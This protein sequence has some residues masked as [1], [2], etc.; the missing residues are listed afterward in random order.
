MSIASIASSSACTG[1][2]D[3]AVTLPAGVNPRP[4]TA[5]AIRCAS[6]VSR[7]VTPPALR[8]WTDSSTRSA[9]RSARRCPSASAPP[10]A[11][12]AAATALPWA[13]DRTGTDTASAPSR[14]R[15]PM[16]ATAAE[17]AVR[18]NGASRSGSAIQS[19]C[20]KGF[21]PERTPAPLIGRLTPHSRSVLPRG[22]GQQAG[23]GPCRILEYRRVPET[24]QHLHD[25]AGN[26]AIVGGG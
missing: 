15:Q 24:G 18:D 11:T 25:R 1:R 17:A 2:G 5:A 9:R 13:S 26:D 8:F 23:G 19:E 10:A 22:E 6:A 20:Q 7:P 4:A 12:A 16:S 14:Y 21:H 3:A